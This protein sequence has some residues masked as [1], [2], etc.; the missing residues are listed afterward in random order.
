MNQIEIRVEFKSS[1]SSVFFH[2]SLCNRLNFVAV[3]I[4][5]SPSFISAVHMYMT[6]FNNISSIYF[7]GTHD[8]TTDPVPT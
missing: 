1:L 8:P 6:Y 4:I 2:A 5:L 7:T 3:R